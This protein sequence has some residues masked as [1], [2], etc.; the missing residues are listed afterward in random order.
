MSAKH[1]SYIIVLSS[2]T[3]QQRGIAPL[4]ESRRSNAMDR[5]TGVASVV[6]AA[7]ELGVSWNAAR[8]TET[9]TELAEASV[10]ANVSPVLVPWHPAGEFQ[11]LG[12]RRTRLLGRG[13]APL[14]TGP[15]GIVERMLNASEKLK[16]AGNVS[17]PL[18][19]TGELQTAFKLAALAPRASGWMS[20]DTR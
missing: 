5:G 19:N 11:G 4:H 20:N 2:S 1:L 14:Q 6:I 12:I 8:S 3:T 9:V 18:S 13:S 7:C 16:V 10:R 17:R 15:V